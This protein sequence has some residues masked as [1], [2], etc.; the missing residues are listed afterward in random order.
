V[1]RGQVIY[2][3]DYGMNSVLAYFDHNI[4]ENEAQLSGGASYF[5]HSN[6]YVVA[7][8]ESFLAF[9]Q[10]RPDYLLFIC[11]RPPQAGEIR[12]LASDNGY[13][14]E[15]VFPGQVIAKS[16]FDVYQTYLLYRRGDL[17]GQT[18]PGW[19]ERTNEVSLVRE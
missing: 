11:W 7:D 19:N 15:R 12:A 2:G 3:F 17:P 18:S 9:R 6:A 1:D 13:V 4:F 14:L 8:R 10:R 16:S 5:H